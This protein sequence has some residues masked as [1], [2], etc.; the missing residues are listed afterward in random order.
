MLGLISLIFVLIILFA[1]TYHIIV[2]QQRWEYTLRAVR[3]SRRYSH[4]LQDQHVHQ[5]PPPSCPDN[6]CA[7]KDKYNLTFLTTMLLSSKFKDN[8]NVANGKCIAKVMSQAVPTI[9]KR[10]AAQGLDGNKIDYND[11]VVRKIVN[12]VVTSTM[13]TGIC[14]GMVL[15][16]KPAVCPTPI[17]N[18]K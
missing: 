12:E 3:E 16:P 14:S 18:Y 17:V 5:P 13:E 11:P 9:S 6:S 15:P 1:I 10:V 7:E 4:E 2:A 8:P